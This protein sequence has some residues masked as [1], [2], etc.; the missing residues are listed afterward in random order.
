NKALVACGVAAGAALLFRSTAAVFLPVLG[1]WFLVVGY[2][3]RDLR[4]AVRYGAWFSLGAVA[5]LAVLVVSN[6]WRYGS[7]LSFGYGQTGAHLHGIRA[8]GSLLTGL[9]GLWLSPGKSVF[10]YA[11]FALL[12]IAGIVI[13]LRRLPAETSLLVALVLANTVLFARVRFWSGDWAWGP[14]YMIIVLP[15]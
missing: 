5:S 14:R 3:K 11:P 6:L 7:A 13:S 12:A 4:T 15:C 8:R 9:W 2:R 10:L 1:V